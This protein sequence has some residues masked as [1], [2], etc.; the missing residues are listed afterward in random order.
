M[1]AVAVASAVLLPASVVSSVLSHMVIVDQDSR[2]RAA[3]TAG[4]FWAISVPLTIAVFFLG[5]VWY[6]SGAG[7]AKDDRGLTRKN[8]KALQREFDV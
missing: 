6:K 7:K 2:L 1:K 4:L 5:L 8:L 3:P